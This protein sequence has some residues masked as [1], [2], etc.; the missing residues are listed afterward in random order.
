[1][2]ATSQ[3]VVLNHLDQALRKPF[4]KIRKKIIIYMNN[5]KVHQ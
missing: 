3:L 5:Q 2:Q 1:M 4:S